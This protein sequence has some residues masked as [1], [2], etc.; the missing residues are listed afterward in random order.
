MRMANEDDQRIVRA[1]VS[2]PGNRLLGFLPSLSAR[3]AV[4][5]GAG[6]PVAT[7]LRFSELPE[8]YIPR[9]E[10]VWGG[11]VDAGQSVSRNLVAAIV[12]RWRGL[13]TAKPAV[14]T[15]RPAVSGAEA[16]FFSVDSVSNRPGTES[17]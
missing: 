8:A 16:S 10:A 7:R 15:I 14:Q 12:A 9:S 6:V 1:A 13:A 2:D 17:R 11:R 5:F 4:A 3:E